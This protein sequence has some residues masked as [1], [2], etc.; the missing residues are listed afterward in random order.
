[1]IQATQET[2]LELPSGARARALRT[3]RDGAPVVL[4]LHGAA[5]NANT[6]ALCREAWSWADLW[7]LDLPGRGGSDGPPRDAVS[8][9]AAFVRAAIETA[10]IRPLVVGHSLGGGVALE[11]GLSSPDILRGIV[12]I[13]SGA[14]LRV[15]PQILEAARTATEP[16]R[17]DFA[18]ADRSVAPAYQA[19]ANET[20][21]ATTAA[22]WAACDG[23]DVRERLPSLRAP[24]ALVWG[25]ADALTPPKFQHWLAEATGA[26]TQELEGM[27]HMLP[28][29][30][31]DAVAEAVRTWTPS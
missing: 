7:C 11:L 26:H 2:I 16:L 4:L 15:S 30:A 28:W 8:D 6:F 12:M 24:L 31:P 20:P 27:G 23:F 1:M 9:L 21:L 19:V 29:E 17:L 5:G 13:S 18:F 14:R 22:D 10:G 3:P 25:S